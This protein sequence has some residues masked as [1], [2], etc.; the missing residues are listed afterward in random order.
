MVKDLYE[1]R[2]IPKEEF[3]GKAPIYVLGLPEDLDN[4]EKQIESILKDKLEES[5]K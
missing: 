2:R 1:I 4:L 5:F 3:G